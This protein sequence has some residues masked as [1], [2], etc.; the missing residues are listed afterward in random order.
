MNRRW[1][2]PIAVFLS[3]TMLFFSLPVSLSGQQDT[4]G[5]GKLVIAIIDLEGR[6]ISALEAATLTDRMRSCLLYTS[7]STRAS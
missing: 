7:P 2:K 1:M 3:W 6:G 5:S 4:Q